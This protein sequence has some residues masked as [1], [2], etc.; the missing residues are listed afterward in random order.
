MEIKITAEQEAEE[1]LKYMNTLEFAFS[2]EGLIYFKQIDRAF[3]MDGDMYR[4]VV[5]FHD[6]GLAFFKYDSHKFN[7]KDFTIYEISKEYAADPT[8]LVNIYR[9]K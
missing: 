6:E 7:L 1:Y 8:K 4:Y 2:D 3:M 5:S 9:R